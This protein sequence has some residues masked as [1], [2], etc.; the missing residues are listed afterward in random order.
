MLDLLLPP[1]AKPLFQELYE[2][3]NYD[4]EALRVQCDKHLAYLTK[5]GRSDEFVEVELA[6]RLARACQVLLTLAQQ[7][8]TSL[9]HKT[10]I[11]VAVRYF[12]ADDPADDDAEIG[13]LDS[14]ADVLNAVATH[15]KQRQLC[16]SK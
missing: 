4:W 5:L 3:P 1:E 14:D 7:E 9:E 16:V 12:I 8:S 13:G 6:Q 11:Q 15:L 10:Y 2:S